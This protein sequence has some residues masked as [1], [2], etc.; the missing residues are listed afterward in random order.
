MGFV[1]SGHRP[2]GCQ[3][4]IPARVSTGCATDRKVK[5][6]RGNQPTGVCI[7][8]SSGTDCNLRNW[9]REEISFTEMRQK[10]NT[11][12]VDSNVNE[13]VRRQRLYSGQLFVISPRPAT[14]AL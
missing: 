14:V 8:F 6:S 3:L 13:E 1:H 2:R 9:L 10:M 11:V 4:R 5:L 7:G 12:Y